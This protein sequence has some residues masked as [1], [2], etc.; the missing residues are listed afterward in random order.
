MDA[1]S[2]SPIDVTKDL[3][4]PRHDPLSVTRV[5]DE[6]HNTFGLFEPALEELAKRPWFRRRWTVQEILLQQNRYILLGSRYTRFSNFL[7]LASC[8]YK[9]PGIYSAAGTRP[10]TRSNSLPKGWSWQSHMLDRRANL[11]TN[12][13]VFRHMQCTKALDRIYA[14]RAISTDGDQIR[15]DYKRTVAEVYIE[16]ASI[17]ARSTWLPGLLIAAAGIRPW[18]NPDM[19]SDEIERLPSWVPDWRLS[20]FEPTFPGFETTSLEEYRSG[21]RLGTC[22][23]A[24]LSMPKIKAIGGTARALIMDCWTTL[25]CTHLWHEP[26]CLHCFVNLKAARPRRRS[27]GLQEHGGSTI[28][29]LLD[30]SSVLFAFSYVHDSTTVA[31]GSDDE[32]PSYTLMFFLG[33]KHV[34]PVN[35][36]TNSADTACFN[37]YLETDDFEVSKLLMRRRKIRV[38]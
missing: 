2:S 24:R 21:R 35:T 30:E 29:C 3:M 15:V 18:W 1:A 14:L 13:V 27:H 25:S 20:R 36:I 22:A 5:E 38:V 9:L 6:L 10:R 7:S 17:Y 33:L 37:F 26:S 28:Y 19:T 32:A 34:T 16:F 23:F 11:L 12:M 8:V 31:N 4:R